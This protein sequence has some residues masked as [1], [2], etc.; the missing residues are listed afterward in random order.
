MG[1]G[2]ISPARTNAMLAG[3]GLLADEQ[4]LLEDILLTSRSRVLARPTGSSQRPWRETPAS[5]RSPIRLNTLTEQET[6]ASSS[7][8]VIPQRP[9]L[10]SQHPGIRFQSAYGNLPWP[11]PTE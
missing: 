9:G 6:L 10:G 7:G 4:P 2:S 11:R 1:W 3:K 5:H 8:S